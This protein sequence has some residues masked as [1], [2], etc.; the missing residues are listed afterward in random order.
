MRIIQ[1]SKK[2]K[3]KNIPYLGPNLLFYCDECALPIIVSSTCPICKK[4][5][6]LLKLTPPYDVKPATAFETL[7]I[8][9]LISSNFGD[10]AIIIQKDDTILLNHVGSE[11]HLEEII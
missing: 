7:E 10:N 11:D 9:E 6:D 8:Q 3:K 2:K 5:V 4:T 1:P